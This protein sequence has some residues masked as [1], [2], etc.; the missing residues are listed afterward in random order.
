[1]ETK[2]VKPIKVELFTLCEG[3]YNHSGHLTIVNTYDNIAVKQLPTRVSFGLA[4]KLYIQ[5][6]VEGD[7]LLTIEIFNDQKE[8][9]LKERLQAKIQIERVDCITHVAL[10]VNFQNVIFTTI[11]KHDVHLEIDGNKLDNFAFEV[12]HE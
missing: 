8:N 2:K 10:A 1:M 3:A 5:P 11:G 7:K 9:I 6:Q 4:L 12:L